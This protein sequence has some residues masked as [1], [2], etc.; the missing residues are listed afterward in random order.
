VSD[1]VCGP[2]PGF[3]CYGRA[4]N[5]AQAFCTKADCKTDA[6]CDFPG[7]YCATVDKAP[8]VRERARSFGE[9][10][11]WCLPR[12]QCAPC[13]SDAECSD[14]DGPQACIKDNTGA[15]YCM[16]TCSANGECKRDHA[17]SDKDGQRVCFPIGGACRGDGTICA[18]CSN[19]DECASKFCL[20]D[21]YTDERSCAAEA[22]T[23]RCEYQRCRVMGGNPVNSDC[24]SNKCIPESASSGICAAAA[25][26]EPRDAGAP[27]AD[28]DGGGADAGVYVAGSCRGTNVPDK[29]YRLCLELK[30]KP[31]C[32]GRKDLPGG[33][34]YPGCY[35][36]DT[37]AR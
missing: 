24:E 18:R 17:C 20:S 33:G 3:K 27:D 34:S 7:Y 26:K 5:D 4:P 22:D 23:A 16:K 13:K 9:T 32:T 6:D 12:T 8:N 35:S 30:G 10:V 1:D 21:T 25:T 36:R 14:A 31:Y 29:A 15:S 37:A 2:V 19:D 28:V 11:K